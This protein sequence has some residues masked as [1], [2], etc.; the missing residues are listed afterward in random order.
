[1]NP[2]EKLFIPHGVQS[3]PV[4]GFC[5]EVATVQGHAQHV[6]FDTWASRAATWAHVLTR[7]NL[8]GEKR[9]KVTEDAKETKQPL[10]LIPSLHQEREY[11]GMKRGKRLIKLLKKK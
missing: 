9:I 7:D 2:E 1:M 8:S 4:D 10:Y 6:H 5:A 3:V 11:S